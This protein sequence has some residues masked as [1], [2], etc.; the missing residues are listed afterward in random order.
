MPPWNMG[1]RLLG[2]GDTATHY[3]P[4][5]CKIFVKQI[6]SKGLLVL[7]CKAAKGE[8]DGVGPVNSSLVAGGGGGTRTFVCRID[9]FGSCRRGSQ[10][11]TPTQTT[12]EAPVDD[13]GGGGLPGDGCGTARQDEV[14]G[15]EAGPP[16]REPPW[17]LIVILTGIGMGISNAADGQFSPMLNRVYQTPV[18]SLRT[19]GG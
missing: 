17:V 7:F 13:I 11:H 4:I 8:V 15:A 14:G 10:G 12:R 2:D 19:S 16:P 3:F 5:H 6:R 1:V 18:I 9:G